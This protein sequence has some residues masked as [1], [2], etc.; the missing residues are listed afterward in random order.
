[1]AGDTP[2]AFIITIKEERCECEVADFGVSSTVLCSWRFDTNKCSS[3]ATD[4]ENDAERDGIAGG[5]GGEDGFD[6]LLS[7]SLLSVSFSLSVTVLRRLD[8]L[9][10]SMDTTAAP[11]IESAR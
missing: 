5:G 7:L 6:S 1:M 3:P 9:D 10:M 11:T 4:D 2:G 8:E